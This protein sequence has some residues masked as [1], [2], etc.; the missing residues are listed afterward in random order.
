MKNLQNKIYRLFSPS[1]LLISVFLLFYTFYKSEIYWDGDKR[2]FYLTYYIISF[3]LIIFSIITFYL[4]Q[5]IKEYLIILLFSTVVGLYLSE[6]YLTFNYKFS[7][8]YKIYERE[9]GK[10]WDKRSHIEIYEDLKKTN[11]NIKVRVFP[12]SY[13][14]PTT[15]MINQ[16]NNLFPLSGISNSKTVYG[17]ELGYYF[18]YDSDRYGFN[19]PDEEWDQ[20]EF[21]YMLVGDSFAH[22]AN[23]NR[24]N[25]IASVLRNLSNKSVLNIGY[26]GNGPLLEYASL[27]EYY[28]SNIKKVLWLYSENND[29][30]NLGQE[31]TNKRLKTY[32]YDLTFT[33]NLK[34]RQDEID[35]LAER[36]MEKQNDSVSYR[37]GFRFMFFKFIKIYNVRY[38]LTPHPKKKTK[39]RPEFK[40]ILKL[41]KNLIE[42]N[43]SELYF[44]YLPEYSRYEKK[45]YDNTSYN[46]VK[47]IVNELNIPFIDIHTEVF[48]KLEDPLNY[49]PFK[50]YNPHYTVEGYKKV[51]EKIYELTNN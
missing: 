49:F 40:K 24:P 42:K 27:R 7:S 34:S 3:L 1:F 46:F 11:K 13:L 8:K 37:E 9:T 6:S 15:A 10:K 39:P 2:N 36:T 20:N 38:L 18:I 5:K 16:N 33:Q 32:L 30:A 48:E 19:N 21:E 44:V 29:L 41:A 47:N 12:V 25:D 31:L 23:V 51:T 28:N 43:N 35:D 50:L 22:G 45:N 17:N 14:E 4:N 26:G